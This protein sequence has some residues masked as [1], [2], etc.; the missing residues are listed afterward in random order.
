MQLLDPLRSRLH[1][2]KDILVVVGVSALV[3]CNRPSA[4]HIPPKSLQPVV[5]T[6]ENVAHSTL[7]AKNTLIGTLSSPRKIQIFNQEEGRILRLPY[8]EGDSVEKGVEL[9]RLDDEVIRAKLVKANAERRQAELDLSRMQK[10]LTRNA[11]SQDEV[12]RA[13]TALELAQAE[14]NFQRIILRRMTIRAPFTGVVSERLKEPGDVAQTYTHILTLIDPSALS[15][16]VNVSEV[17]LSQLEVGAVVNIHIDAL[18]DHTYVGHIRRI[19]PVIDPQ[20]RQGLVEVTLQPPPRGARPGQLARITF[21]TDKT[22]G[23]VVPFSALRHD[24]EGAFVYRVEAD[25]TARRKPVR[26]GVQIGDRIEILQGLNEGD[27]VIVRGLLKI[28]DGR[29]VRIVNTDDL[30]TD[31]T[32]LVTPSQS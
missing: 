10:L 3:A 7:T 4:D 8:Y 29:K 14:E 22:A 12:A 25:N 1:W 19:H 13:R 20:S 2:I 18:Q 26:T 6:T 21:S 27:R 28:K 9:V 11:A 16:E 31:Q 15:A 23:L 32:V 17:L 24:N 30:E 5:V